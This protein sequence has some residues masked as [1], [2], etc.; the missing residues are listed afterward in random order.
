MP[1]HPPP[2]PPLQ[3]GGL[4]SELVPRHLMDPFERSLHAVLTDNPYG[5]TT[6]IREAFGEG[7]LLSHLWDLLWRSHAVPAVPMPDSQLE[8]RDHFLLQYSKALGA[9]PALWQLS[10]AY[11]IELMI[12]SKPK[13]AAR[14]C[15]VQILQ[16][17]V[18]RHKFALRKALHIC[19]QFELEAT[20]QQLVKKHFAR[21]NTH[22]VRSSEAPPLLLAD[23]A[24][25]LASR[26]ETLA[27][28]SLDEMQ[29]ILIARPKNNSAQA[30]STK[31]DVGSATMQ[32][33]LLLRLTG[34]RHYSGPSWLPA[35]FELSRLL[36]QGVTQLPHAKAQWRIIQLFT[37]PN[38]PPQL[39]RRLLRLFAASEWQQASLHTLDVPMAASPRWARLRRAKVS[40]AVSDY[41]NE[42]PAVNELAFHV[43]YSSQDDCLTVST[44]PHQVGI[45]LF[46]VTDN[47]TMMTKALEIKRYSRHSSTEI[48]RELEGR[49]GTQTQFEQVVQCEAS[50]LGVSCLFRPNQCLTCIFVTFPFSSNPLASVINISLYQLQLSLSL[51]HNLAEAVLHAG[52]SASKLAIWESGS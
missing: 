24:G 41:G 28:A 25:A 16:E 50:P 6:A 20:A 37:D 29:A 14:K 17:R 47:Y 9:R 38:R 31:E 30:C 33:A 43:Y 8:Y 40:A 13:L 32:L 26:Y 42:Q 21:S 4:L 34:P 44:A 2:R 39:L 35:F 46:G 36:C 22:A 11:V 27:N 5:A 7:W 3:L 19:E 45:L 23:E 12:P 18:P 49:T 1:S 51:S 15:L 10:A 52:L 48:V